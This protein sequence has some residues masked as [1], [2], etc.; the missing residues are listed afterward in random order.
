[1]RSPTPTA[2]DSL[3]P[4]LLSSWRTYLG[5]GATELTPL[6]N[7]QVGADSRL[8]LHT[9]LDRCASTERYC[10]RIRCHGSSPWKNVVAQCSR[11]S[12]AVAV[13]LLLPGKAPLTAQ[14]KSRATWSMLIPNVETVSPGTWKFDVALLEK[15]RGGRKPRFEARRLRTVREYRSEGW[16]RGGHDHRTS[17]G[18]VML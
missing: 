9:R 3:D 12:V 8:R 14:C 15:T 13:R 6:L 11:P 1:M 5:L 2:S 7:H 17:R 18:K 16:R 4:E 10:K